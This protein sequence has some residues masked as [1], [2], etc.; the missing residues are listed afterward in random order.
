MSSE[1]ARKT[2]LVALGVCLVCSV[3]VSGSV[4]ILRQRQQDNKELDKLKNILQAANLYTD[5]AAVKTTFREKIRPVLVDLTNGQ[6]VSDAPADKRLDLVRFDLKAIAR[7]PELS[8]TIPTAK[9][10]AH[11]GRQPRYMVVYNVIENDQVAG[12]IL[13]VYGKGL[14]STMYGFIALKNDI[15]TV[16]GFIFYEHGETPG[17]GGEVD[18]PLW[19]AQWVGKQAFDKSG[20]LKIE[21]IKGK[22]DPA[23]PLARY[24]IDGLSGATLTTRGVDHLVKF[25]LG[26][27]GYEPLL[28][29]LRAK[30]VV[31]E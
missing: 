24:Q 23:S 18:N 3:L 21:V 13:P 20:A 11:I 5:D 2:V 12:L 9:D 22:V 1:S 7:D 10:L 31:H 4:V 25:W 8:R 6:I 26:A 16:A 28:N 29:N 30:A 17:L 19:R 14:W 27:N 15:Q